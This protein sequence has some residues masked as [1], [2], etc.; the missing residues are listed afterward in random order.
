MCLLSPNSSQ[1]HTLSFSPN[2]VPFPPLLRRPICVVQ[3]FL[4]IRPSTA[5][6]LSGA[7]HL[8]RVLH[9]QSL[10][11]ANSSSAR[12]EIVCPTSPYVLGFGLT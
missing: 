3:V 7:I 2:F 8:E 5:A 9:S 10:T 4:N 11:I 6:N 12:G 1:V